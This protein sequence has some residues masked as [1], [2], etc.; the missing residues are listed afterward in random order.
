MVFFGADHSSVVNDSLGALRVQLSADMGLTEVVWKPVW[1]T[2]FPMFEYDPDAKRWM[3]MHHP[4]TAPKET[5]LEHVDTD[6]ANVQ[7]RAYDLVVNGTEIGGGSVR[8]HRL[9]IQ[10]KVFAALGIEQQE[11][12]EKFGFLLEALKY[13]APPH[14]GIAFG[15]D[16]IVALMAGAE[17]CA[18][19]PRPRRKR[20]PSTLL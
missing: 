10:Q 19:Q 16:R 1:I 9:E 3:A 6:P 13:G 20:N 14:G 18:S 4:F 17:C 7:S 12:Q 11:A 8:N 5:D 2:D 15:L